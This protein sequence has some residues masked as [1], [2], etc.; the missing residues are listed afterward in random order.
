VTP[1]PRPFARPEASTFAGLRDRHG[2]FQLHSRLNRYNPQDAQFPRGTLPFPKEALDV[3]SR[4][5]LLPVLGAARRPALGLV[6]SLAAGCAHHGAAAPQVSVARI[7][8]PPELVTTAATVPVEPL[9]DSASGVNPKP[10]AEKASP[11]SRAVADGHA[12]PIAVDN[13]PCQ[14]LTLPDAIALAFRL[15]PRLRASLES[16]EQ[17]RG[18][19]DIAFAAFLPVLTSAYSV[20]GVRP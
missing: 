14:A 20:G 16:I 2:S 1:L 11:A 10:D 18:N 3:L 4:A 17:A 19:E 8:P 5:R 15:Q 7:L 9:P 6:L 12:R 13:V